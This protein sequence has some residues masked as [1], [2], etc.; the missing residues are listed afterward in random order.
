MATLEL[1]ESALKDNQVQSAPSRTLRES[2]E[3]AMRNY[4]S[5]LGEQSPNEIYDMVMQEIEPPLFEEV[6]RY[7][8]GNQSKAALILGISRGTLRKKLK[9][10]AI[11]KSKRRELP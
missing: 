5:Q 9:R 8:R 4:F 11:E 1:P 10:Y 7:V 3:L 2:V 6:M